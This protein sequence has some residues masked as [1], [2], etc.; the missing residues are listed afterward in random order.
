MKKKCK[1]ERKDNNYTIIQDYFSPF[2]PSRP[3]RRPP[4]WPSLP[5]PLPPRRPRGIRCRRRR[6]LGACD[7]PAL[8][9]ATRAPATA[10][11]FVSSLAPFHILIVARL[12]C[13]FFAP[14]LRWH[15]LRLMHTL[16]PGLV[17]S[18]HTRRAAT[19]SAA[20]STPSSESTPAP[21]NVRGPRPTGF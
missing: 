18:T 6:A 12:G 15:H 3:R 20:P 16:Q 8:Q 10:S 14:R 5:P 13:S 9:C 1:H 19:P 11:A 17:R 4:L 21:T 2:W 7:A